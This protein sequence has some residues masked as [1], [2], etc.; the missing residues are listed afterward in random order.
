L[1]WWQKQLSRGSHIKSMAHLVSLKKIIEIV[2]TIG[3]AAILKF[4]MIQKS[5]KKNVENHPM[6]IF[7]KFGT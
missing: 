7:A 6:K 1:Q 2:A 4:R 5:L 3:L